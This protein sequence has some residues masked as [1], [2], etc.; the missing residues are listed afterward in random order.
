VFSA[1]RLDD[2]IFVTFYV[3]EALVS[4]GPHRYKDNRYHVCLFL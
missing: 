1:M 2:S 4:G 3:F